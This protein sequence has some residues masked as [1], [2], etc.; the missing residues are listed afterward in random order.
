MTDNLLR[1]IS[2]LLARRKEYEGRKK[3]IL[4]IIETGNQQ[5]RAVAEDTMGTVR[6]AVQLE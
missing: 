6:R 4:D 3:E 5:A 2:P 1:E